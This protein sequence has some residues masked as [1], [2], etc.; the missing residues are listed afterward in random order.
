MFFY[1]QIRWGCKMVQLKNEK[2]QNIDNI[3]DNILT[4]MKRVKI[5]LCS[6]LK[7]DKLLKLSKQSRSKHKNTGK[8][9]LSK[10]YTK[11]S[12]CQGNDQC[13]EDNP[14][15]SMIFISWDFLLLQKN[16]SK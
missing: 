16:I 7:S 8:V 5:A 15:S 3:H 11:F 12:F 6:N 14:R 10:L 4:K 1:L 13:S 2:G 9:L